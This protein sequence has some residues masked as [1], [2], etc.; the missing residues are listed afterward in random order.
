ML[1][2]ISSKPHT[3]PFFR[4]P[5]ISAP[6]S[7]AVEVH[8]AAP[9][10]PCSRNMEHGAHL[11][12]PPHTKHKPCSARTASAHQKHTSRTRPKGLSPADSVSATPSLLLGSAVGR[13]ALRKPFFQTWSCAQVDMSTSAACSITLRRLSLGPSDHT[14]FMY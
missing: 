2:G 5:A 4:W 1:I 6:A 3:H 10:H 12:L 14:I 7:Q 8:P 13:E 11:D 9:M